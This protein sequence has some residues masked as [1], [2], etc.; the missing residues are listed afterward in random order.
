MAHDGGLSSI[1]RTMD[2]MAP[3]R[4]TIAV[5]LIVITCIKVLC[6]PAY[7]S[8]DFD[9]HRNWKAL[10]RHQPIEEWYF[11][12]VNKTTVHTLDYPPAFA[13]FEKMWSTNP[14]TE[15]LLSLQILDERC[16]AQLPDTDNTPSSACVAF[17]RSTVI[18][19]DVILWLGAW[20]A[21]SPNRTSFLLI[22]LNPGLLWLDHIHFQYN[23]MLLGLLLASLGLL[24][25]EAQGWK[26][27]LNV[28]MAAI[29]YCLLISM[30]HLYVPLAPIYA[31]H[32]LRYYCH[33][34]GKF[35]FSRLVYLAVL[36][37]TCLLLFFLP[38]MEKSQLQQII[39]RLFPF[40][41][42]LC[43]D[44]PAAN[45]WS[46]YQVG[47]K[48]YQFVAR[49][50]GYNVGASLPEITP[51]TTAVLLFL[52]LLPACYY[53]YQQKSKL[54]HCVVYCSFCT[55]MLSFHVH[56][57]A[58]LTALIPLTL[59]A[60]SCVELTRLYLRTCAIGLLGLFPLLFEPG[61]LLLKVLS[62]VAFLAMAVYLL[63]TRHGVSLLTTVDVVGMAV[64]GM[65]AL[66]L[67][68]IHPLLLYPWMEALPLLLT[69][70]VCA[71]GLIWYC[72]LESGRL[73]M[74]TSTKLG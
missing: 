20:V 7:R 48:C 11:D 56:E 70:V 71:V 50:L 52:S 6:M 4:R 19:S 35:Q 55:F 68:V 64:L 41:R 60:P 26:R 62:Y 12:T 63:E 53:A 16:L 38:F 61:E 37:S 67:E 46:L 45:I 30:K 51:L 42:G 57:K 59:L 69:S 17:Q 9:V 14:I 44:Y 2:A 15:R 22:V 18:F 73:M 8:T 1:S 29:L 23:G 74:R 21:T 58:I 72:W 27:H 47:E 10:T 49:R 32:L 34:D 5:A 3:R 13:Y 31:A 40:G 43:H 66:F 24:T 65:V 54:I 36:T 39:Q 28:T 33:V 25:R